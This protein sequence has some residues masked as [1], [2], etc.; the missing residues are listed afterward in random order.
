M[1]DELLPTIQ[2]AWSSE[3]SRMPL[4]RTWSQFFDT[5][6][7]LTGRLIG[8]IGG[9]VLV[10]ILAFIVM[11]LLRRVVVGFV[12]RIIERGGRSSEELTQKANTLADV[13]L[14][15]GKLMVIIIASMMILSSLGVNIVP[16]LASAGIAGVAIGLGAQSLIRDMINGFFILSE[17][18]FG[19]GD[20]VVIGAF[21]GTVEEISLRRTALR[22]ADGSAVFIP[23]G[24]ITA[25]VNQ[26]RGWANAIVDIVVRP[27]ANDADVLQA[28]REA[29]Q[30]VENDPELGDVILEP[31]RVLGITAITV[32]GVNFRASV[33][34]KPLRH[35]AVER[36]LRRRVIQHF[37]ER[38]IPMLGISTTASTEVG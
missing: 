29:L 34:T 31:V 19:V 6:I 33:R 20:T 14:S 26:S 22:T 9:A 11:R 36:E 10:V 18:Q 17:D 1:Q 25:V 3:L 28:L 12:A 2:H 38:G 13:V 27:E 24:T 35:L 5:V 15:T 30:G 4:A 23:N 16:L 37:R 32:D 8:S 21:S 7:D